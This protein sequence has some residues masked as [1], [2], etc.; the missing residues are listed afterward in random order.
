MGSE[1][2]SRATQLRRWYSEVDAGSGSQTLRH[3]DPRIRR[4]ILYRRMQRSWRLF[5]FVRAIRFLERVETISPAGI[6]RNFSALEENL[7]LHRPG[8]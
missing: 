6:D 5:Q 3:S 1:A 4:S 8:I 7:S 2:R